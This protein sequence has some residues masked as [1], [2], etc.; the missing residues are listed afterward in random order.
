MQYIISYDSR[1]WYGS[2]SFF[3]NHIQLGIFVDGNIYPKQISLY[4]ITK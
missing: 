2:N 1:W 3:G 4:N